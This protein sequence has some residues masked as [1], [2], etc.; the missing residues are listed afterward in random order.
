[1]MDI[2]IPVIH[3]IEA[4]V[5]IHEV[6]NHLYEEVF[7]DVMQK[8]SRRVMR[9]GVSPNELKNGMW[10]YECYRSGFEDKLG[11][12]TP[13]EMALFNAFDVLRKHLKDNYK[14]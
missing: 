1:M 2:K 6:F 10:I 14:C 5:D 7:D 3:K 13:E 9:E 8:A 12:A 4:Y 11:P